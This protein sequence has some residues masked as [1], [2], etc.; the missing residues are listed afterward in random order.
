MS[1]TADAASGPVLEIDGARATTKA[2]GTS[3]SMSS[4]LPITA[5]STTPATRLMTVSISD[6]AT[7][8]SPTRSMS[9]AR[10]TK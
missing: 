10:P 5:D 9:F 8:S 2:T 3:S 1:D 4:G 7:F 6:A